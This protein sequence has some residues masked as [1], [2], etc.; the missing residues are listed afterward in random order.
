MKGWKVV[1]IVVMLVAVSAVGWYVQMTV[2][3]RSHS[4]NWGDSAGR[5]FDIYNLPLDPAYGNY[6]RFEISS[7]DGR[8]VDVYLTDQ[9]GLQAARTGGAFEYDAEF[10]AVNTTHIIRELRISEYSQV[11]VMS[12][13]PDGTVRV[14][15]SADQSSY[16]LELMP[17]LQAAWL[18]CLVANLFLIVLLIQAWKRYRRERRSGLS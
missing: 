4:G 8:T 11:V 1:G 15:S 13:D 2:N 9:D 5:G 7:T 14:A 16:P 10:S 17:V 12:H 6:V 3:D 18:I